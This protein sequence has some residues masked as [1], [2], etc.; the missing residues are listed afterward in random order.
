MVLI[1]KDNR[2]ET[3][4]SYLEKALKNYKMMHKLFRTYSTKFIAKHQERVKTVLNV[5]EQLTYYASK[6]TQY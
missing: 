2:T 4:Y 5:F 6:K 3:I 1:I